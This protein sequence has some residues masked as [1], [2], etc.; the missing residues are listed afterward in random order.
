[1]EQ[2][3]CCGANRWLEADICSQC[4]EHADFSDWE[5][6]ANERMKVIGQNGNTGI[7]YTKEKIKEL[8]KQCKVIKR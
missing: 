4:K 3:N 1:M 6:E 2:S 5:E 7:H 8:W